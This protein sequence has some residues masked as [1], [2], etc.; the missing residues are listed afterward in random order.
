[1]EEKIVPSPIMH[2]SQNIRVRLTN[3]VAFDSKL[4]SGLYGSTNGEQVSSILNINAVLNKKK[5]IKLSIQDIR[6]EAL[7]LL[8]AATQI[9]LSPSCK[10]WT[11]AK[12]S[13]IRFFRSY[14]LQQFVS[15]SYS[16]EILKCNK[17][18]CK[19]Y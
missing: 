5:G 18:Y 3:L 4:C 16:E 6:C 17:L 9:F 2:V 15:L 13:L 11:D 7:Y 19:R 12:L 1:M 14:N 10:R 8:V